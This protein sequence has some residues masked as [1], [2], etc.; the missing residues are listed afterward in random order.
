MFIVSVIL[1]SESPLIP[2]E[3]STKVTGRT[4]LPII[5]FSKKNVYFVVFV[6]SF[7]YRHEFG[8]VRFKTHVFPIL[9]LH[10]IQHIGT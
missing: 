10:H 5:A 1:F 4:N 2:D 7:F 8:E 3:Q 6:K 9:F